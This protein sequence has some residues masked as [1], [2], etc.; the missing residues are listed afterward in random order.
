MKN[1]RIAAL[2]FSI[3]C[4]VPGSGCHYDG[5]PANISLSVLQLK[6]QKAMDP[7]GLYRKS[8][9]SSWQFIS[10]TASG[11]V[12]LFGELHGQIGIE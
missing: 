3:L 8:E 11:W 4:I 5:D 9:F 6:M 10:P 2:L 7:D 1:F 12:H